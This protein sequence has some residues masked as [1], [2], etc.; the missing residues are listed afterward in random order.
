MNGVKWLKR[1]S[2][3]PSIIVVPAFVIFSENIHPLT[4]KFY[5]QVWNDEWGQMTEASVSASPSS[6]MLAFVLFS[7]KYPSVV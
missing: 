4:V 6:A 7:K 2:Q 5:T 1:Q 3:R